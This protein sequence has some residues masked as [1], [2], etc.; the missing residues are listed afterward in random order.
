M[1]LKGFECFDLSI[2]TDA[3]LERFH[4]HYNLAYLWRTAEGAVP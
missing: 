4:L 1:Q 2:G 3:A